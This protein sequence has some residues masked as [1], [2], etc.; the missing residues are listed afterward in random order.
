MRK[1]DVINYVVDSFI[2]YKGIE[3]KFIL[4][5]KTTECESAIFEFNEND[6]FITIID[7]TIGNDD[8][9]SGI[10]NLHIGVAICNPND[11]FNEE[12]GKKIALGKAESS[13]PKLISTEP[14]IINNAVVQALIQQEINYIKNNPGRFIP[15]YDE[16]VDKIKKKDKVISEIKNLNNDEAIIVEAALNG[17]NLSKCMKLASKITKSEYNKARSN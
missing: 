12:I 6:D 13:I 16:A 10:R 9:Y 17:V 15:G 2:N 7:D 14:G 5:V 1:S 8:Y 3:Q 11:E 4:C